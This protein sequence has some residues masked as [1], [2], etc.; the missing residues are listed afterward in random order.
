[1]TKKCN[2]CQTKFALAKFGVQLVT[3]ELFQYQSQMFLMF[4]SYLRVNQNVVD[5]DN[6]KLIQVL[7]KHHI[8]EIYEIGWGIH[9]SEGHHDILIV[10]TRYEMLSWG[11]L[12]LKSSADDIP[13]SIRS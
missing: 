2:L 7:H 11:Y 9:K 6:N 12:T 1:M 10:Y 8:H 5:E 13:I 3:C 4:F